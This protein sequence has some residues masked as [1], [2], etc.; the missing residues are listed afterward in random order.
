MIVIRTRAWYAHPAPMI[1]HEPGATPCPKPA[2]AE[3]T[4]IPAPCRFRARREYAGSAVPT[5]HIALLCTL[6][7]KQPT[8]APM[9]VEDFFLAE[10]KRSM[11]TRIFQDLLG[12]AASG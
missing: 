10:E 3:E 2:R 5:A 11:R 1:I 4:A 6:A 12:N 8:A 9:I 7:A